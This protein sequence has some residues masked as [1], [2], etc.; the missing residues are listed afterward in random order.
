MT[1]GRGVGSDPRMF[2]Y[3]VI[4]VGLPDPGLRRDDGGEGR[5]ETDERRIELW[6]R[7]VPLTCAWSQLTHGRYPG[8]A[9]DPRKVLMS[10]GCVSLPGPRHRGDD[11]GEGRAV[12]CRMELLRGAG[13][14]V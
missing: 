9:R 8:V 3:L 4:C 6:R 7:G 12:G 11:G 10:M 14:E 13:F 2:G 1:V 5:A